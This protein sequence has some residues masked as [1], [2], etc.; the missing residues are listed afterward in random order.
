MSELSP[1]STI[2]TPVAR[3]SLTSM[4]LVRPSRRVWVSAKALLALLGLTGAAMLLLPWQQTSPGD[5]RV[6][7]YAPSEREQLV[8]APISGRIVDWSVHEGSR[9]RKGD[10]LLELA[11]NDPQILERLRQ[12]REATAA[13]L[14]A[15]RV[16]ISAYERQIEALRSARELE[17]AAAEA[18]V[19]MAQNKAKAA[20]QTVSAAGAALKTA[21]LN[22]ERLKALVGRGLTSVRDLELAE[23]ALA[24]AETDT[25]AARAELEA[26]RGEVL[27]KRADVSSKGS[28]YDAKISKVSAELQA[29]QAEVEKSRAELTKVDVRLA[30]QAH[31]VV[32]APRDGTI[33][34]VIAREGAEFVKTG[35]P[36]F[37]FVPES[38]RRAVELWIDGNDAPLVR[39]DRKVR[40]QF[41]GWP[42]VQFSGWPSVA[43]GTFGGEVAFVDA[44][45]DRNGR[46]RIVVVADDEGWPEG[47]YLRQGARA[48]GWVLLDEV[49]VGYELWRQLNGFPPRI[50]QPE[51]GKKGGGKGG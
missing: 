37:L 23:L 41:E 28:D 40:L 26:A 4:Q 11:D 47:R 43:L 8:G 6:I 13:R 32:R 31:M 17:I 45:A 19:R 14:E 38:T 34:R 24:K 20:E 49:S 51:A 30:R 7:A 15:K 50:E 46:F 12:E 25:F 9:V 21:R 35:D 5:G 2:G 33:V 27:A 29:G 18:R 39:R 16:G 44:A 48:N 42:A 1:I 22:L 36:L 10:R 3:A